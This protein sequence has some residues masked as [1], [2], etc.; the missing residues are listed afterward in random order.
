MQGPLRTINR[1]QGPP[2]HG[3]VLPAGHLSAELICESA[4]LAAVGQRCTLAGPG[5]WYLLKQPLRLGCGSESRGITPGKSGGVGTESGGVKSKHQGLKHATGL[6]CIGL[7]CSLAWSV[8]LFVLF[9][10]FKAAEVT[11]MC[12]HS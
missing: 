4:L 3:Q 9:Y 5:G 11:F 2:E 7:G 8:I 1:P 6:Y 12:S 10:Y